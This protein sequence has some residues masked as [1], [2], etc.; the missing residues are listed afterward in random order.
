MKDALIFAIEKL[1]LVQFTVLTKVVNKY[2]QIKTSRCTAA[3][4]IR[5]VS[6]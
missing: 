2:R 1:K 6:T 4:A 5:L 3:I